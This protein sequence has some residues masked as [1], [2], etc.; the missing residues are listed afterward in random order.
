MEGRMATEETLEE[1]L[2]RHVAFWECADV[3]RPL[4]SIRPPALPFHARRY[5]LPDG[6]PVGEGMRVEAGMLDMGQ[7]LGDEDRTLQLLDGDFVGSWAPTLFASFSWTEAILGCE[8]SHTL[9]S[10]WANPLK[11]DWTDVARTGDWRQS[12]WLQALMEVNARQVEAAQGRMGVA[13]PLFRGPFDMA[14]AALG[15]EGLC[16]ALVD[17]ADQLAEFLD[18]CA[19]L[20]IDVGQH[21][22][23]ETPAYLGGYFPSSYFGLWAP[24]STVR[25]Q[26]DSSYLVSPK[27]YRERFQRFDRRIAQAFE[28]PAFASHT[29]QA[30]HLSVY[31][32]IPEL[33]VIELTLELPPFG[34]PALALLP[35]VREVQAMGKALLLTGDVTQAELDG[36]LEG[37]S[38]RGLAF[39]VRIRED[40]ERA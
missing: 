4:L 38:P 8:I 12:P 5:L 33:R 31:A 1:V 27:M 9:G 35:P 10:W 32:E 6:S 2:A 26:A 36:L 24:G 30:R 19:D 15:G 3:D 22:L 21:R 23:A 17:R 18:Y 11:E 25:Y 29:T 20:Y 13:Q 28:Y 7:D 34:R 16:L 37:L 14:T 40:D 39:R